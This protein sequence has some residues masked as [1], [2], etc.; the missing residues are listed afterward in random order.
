MRRM[1]EGARE[2]GPITL[3]TATEPDAVES[4]VRLYASMQCRNWK[5]EV[6]TAITQNDD[7]SDFCVDLLRRLAATGRARMFTLKMGE[8]IVA[9]QIAI[10]KDDVLYLLK[11]TY[12]PKL[13]RLGPG[14]MPKYHMMLD[15]YKHTPQVKRMEFYGPLNESQHMWITGS[16]SIYHANAYRSSVLA[17]VHGLWVGSRAVMNKA[18]ANASSSARKY[19]AIA[20]PNDVDIHVLFS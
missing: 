1:R 18:F 19:G 5:A 14:V 13:K 20:I 10:L 3:M 11:P 4:L 15:C 16:R 17:Q 9:A 2:F 12:E 6:S 7:Q 8:R